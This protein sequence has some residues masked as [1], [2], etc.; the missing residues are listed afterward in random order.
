MSHMKIKH[1]LLYILLTVGAINLTAQRLLVPQNL[2]AYDNKIWHF[3]FT[4][5]TDFQNCRISNNSTDVWG[6]PNLKPPTPVYGGTIQSQYFYSEVPHLSTGFQVGI[7]TSRRIGKYFNLRIIPTL[8]LGQKDIKSR[9]F[10]TEDNS[11]NEPITYPTDLE[12]EHTTIKSTYIS[13]PILVKYKAIRIRNIKPYLVAG[14]TLRYDL[15]TSFDEPIT[16]KKFDTLLEFGLGTDFYMASFRLGVEV[17]FGI[18][19][20]NLLETERPNNEP[21]PYITA[22]MDA[23]KS[24]SFT[25][26]INFE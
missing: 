11:E 6:F 24:K 17:R 22:S 2:P 12:P 21:K 10:V 25:V 8:T 15:A 4:L 16:L 19:L 9:M 20:M 14:T 23:L 3:G 1:I 7:I 26:A 13:C 18:G 5:G